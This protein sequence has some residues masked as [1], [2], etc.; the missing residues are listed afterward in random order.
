[1]FDALRKYAV[2]HGRAARREFWLF[3]LLC[4]A[5]WI[6]VQVLFGIHAEAVGGDPHA[7]AGIVVTDFVGV[8]PLFIPSI[9]V[10][11]RRLHDLGHSGWW[12]LAWYGVHAFVIAMALLHESGPV[13]FAALFGYAIYGA[14]FGSTLTEPTGESVWWY[15]EMLILLV[16]LAYF[17]VRGTR[18]G[19]AH[20]PDPL[21][22]AQANEIRD[23]K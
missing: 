11:A 14:I 5:W 6:I 1:M 19:N 23:N 3:L 12:V 21:E 17:C 10:T 2:F 7:E 20:G 13:E 16:P 9:A 22:H 4:L 15:L 8:L 18:G